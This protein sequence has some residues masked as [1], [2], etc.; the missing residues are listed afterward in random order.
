PSATHLLFASGSFGSKEAALVALKAQVEKVSRNLAL[1]ETPEQFQA[2]A[3][4]FEGFKGQEKTLQAEIGSLRRQAGQGQRAEARGGGGGGQG[5]GG[6]GWG[7]GR[8]GGEITLLPA[9]SP[10]RSI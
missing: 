5:R 2:I 4:Q 9:T 8:P 6:G 1:A 10:A 7:S 3:A